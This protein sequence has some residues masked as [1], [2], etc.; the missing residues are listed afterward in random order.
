MKMK[1]FVNKSKR[2]Q[3]HVIEVV[4]L[5]VVVL[6][7][8]LP[9]FSNIGNSL[10]SKAGEINDYLDAEDGG[11]DT[12]SGALPAELLHTVSDEVAKIQ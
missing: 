3:G 11:G 2:G 9:M 5:I 6:L 10:N 7:V 8:A 1:N 12:G 4:L